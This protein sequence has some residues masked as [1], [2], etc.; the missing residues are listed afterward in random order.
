MNL[1]Y[2]VDSIGL[3]Q[4]LKTKNKKQISIVVYYKNIFLFYIVIFLLA[5]NN[6]NMKKK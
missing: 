4:K 2:F 1:K 5:T 6:K 3:F